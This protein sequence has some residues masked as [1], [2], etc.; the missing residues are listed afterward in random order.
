MSRK[1]K[2]Q[3]LEEVAAKKA[4]R[5]G[6]N[7]RAKVG[8]SAGIVKRRK[9]TKMTTGTKKK[10]KSR[11]S[12]TEAPNKK[13]PVEMPMTVDENIPATSY[14]PQEQEEPQLHEICTVASLMAPAEARSTPTADLACLEQALAPTGSWEEKENGTCQSEVVTERQIPEPSLGSR[15]LHCLTT[16]W[17]WT[18]RHIRTGQP[19]K[20]LRVCESVSLG[21]K[22]FVAVIEVDGEQFLVGGASSSVATLARLEPAQEFSQALQQRW[23]QDPIQA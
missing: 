16:V 8:D 9:T 19:K 5:R 7:I 14:T 21:E 6:R 10:T 3:K 15:I 2:E 20:R 13:E 17:K 18:R 4:I 23:A 12:K 1:V 11:V 22:R